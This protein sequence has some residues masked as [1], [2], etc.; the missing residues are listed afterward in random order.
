MDSQEEP[1]TNFSHLQIDT[2]QCSFIDEN[3]S[4][5]DINLFKELESVKNLNKVIENAIS[6]LSKAQK[7]MELVELVVNDTD[8]LLEKWIKILN[9][10]EHTQRLILNKK[11]YGATKDLLD[12]ENEQSKII[13]KTLETKSFEVMEKKTTIKE[14]KKELSNISY[15]NNSYATQRKRTK[16]KESANIST[17]SKKSTLSSTSKENTKKSYRK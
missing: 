6:G 2:Q 16:Q 11:W 1:L 4:E 8:K 13:E 17:Q 7:N 10:A 5:R 15:I 3:A 12:I 14:N 9:Q